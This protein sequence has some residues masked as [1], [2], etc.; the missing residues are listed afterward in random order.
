MC[1][2]IASLNVVAVE[3]VSPVFVTV[4]VYSNT[5]PGCAVPV[6]R[7][8]L[9]A[10]LTAPSTGLA[11]T[12]VVTDLPNRGTVYYQMNFD[13]LDLRKRTIEWSGAY[14]VKVDR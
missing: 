13:V 5:S 14:E 8:R 3:A 10:A 9:R 1:A 7:V 12:G 2:G 6:G 11:L 4:M